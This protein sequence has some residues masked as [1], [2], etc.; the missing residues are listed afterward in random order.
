MPRPSCVRRLCVVLATLGVAL[1]PLRAGAEPVTKIAVTP[2]GPAGTLKLARAKPAPE[3]PAAAQVEVVMAHPELVKIDAVNPA[4]AKPKVNV[5][6]GAATVEVKPGEQ[7]VVRAP[8]SEASAAATTL[9]PAKKALLESTVIVGVKDAD[10]GV[11]ARQLRPFVLAEVSPLRW[12][13]KTKQYRTTLL[14]GL[15]AAEG[16]ASSAPLEL[17]PP[18]VF[19]LTGENVDQLEP[20][21]AAVAVAGPEGYQRVSVSSRSFSAPIKV[22]AHS[23]AGDGSFNAPVDPGPTWFDLGPSDG[24][25]DGFG[26]GKTTIGVRQRAANGEPLLA[27]TPLRVEL[28]T[29]AGALTPPY[30][31]IPAG[32]ASGQTLLISAAW[33]A[34]QVSESSSLGAERAVSIGFSFPWL[35]FALGILGAASAGALRA[36]MGKQTKQARRLSFLGCLASGIVMD[37]L[38]AIG[39]PI[40]PDWVLGVIRGELSWFAI[41]L[42]A[43]F[44]GAAG[45]ESLSAKIFGAPKPQPS[46][47]SG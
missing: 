22:S 12:D 37:I 32:Q 43:G 9:A 13:E 17:Q 16:E 27:Q 10:N 23:R 34:A 24:A 25:I 47:T 26:L 11:T 3:K 2:S 15:D 45:L 6:S 7:L 28:K 30:V 40:A 19:Q 35:K 29:T 39:A 18:I 1:V 4:Q 36:L 5:T 41:G 42:L 20:P 44:P 8:A 14:V 46:E 38:L 21:R 31:D 33:G